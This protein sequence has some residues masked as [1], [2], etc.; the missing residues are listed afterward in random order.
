MTAA[1][2]RAVLTEL[3][4]EALGDP[5]LEPQSHDA[6]QDLPGF[7]SGKKVLLILAMEER[8]GIRLRSREVDALRLFG[9]WVNLVSRHLAQTPGGRMVPETLIGAL[10]ASTGHGP[11]L[12]SREGTLD[13]AEL[14]STVRGI[15]T[16][17]A[18]NDVTPGARVAI[19]QRD[20]PWAAA[21][22]LGISRAHAAVPLN[23]GLSA[24]DYGFATDDF[25]VAVM[26]VEQGVVDEARLAEVSVPILTFVPW[27]I[28]PVGNDTL[29]PSL[30][31]SPA[32]LLHT[33]GTTARP[34]KVVLTHERLF[35]GA[36]V[37]ADA[38]KLGPTDRCLTGM[39]M[40]HVHG[41]LNALAATLVSGGSFAHSG[42][43]DTMAFYAHLR[44]FRPT[45]ITAVPTMY[46]AIAARPEQLRADHCI[47]F[48]RTSS[49]PMSD[50]LA[51]RLE[52]LFGVPLL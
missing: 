6:E 3:F 30:P 46:H 25:G 38:L 22:L 45:W 23:P 31:T 39:P 21:M 37:I 33:S 5:R 19:V 12:V 17:L 16:W 2:I 4:R 29:A 36:H 35:R 10:E 48:L 50:V 51:E 7:D 28:H 26:L 42:P 24:A 27:T 8:F 49:A 34:K 41:I 9:D 11:A 1:D 47:R 14:L 40:F 44:E 18:R 32:L 52:G 15:S 20:G 43:F 13:Y